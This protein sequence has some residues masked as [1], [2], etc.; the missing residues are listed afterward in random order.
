MDLDVDRST[1]MPR[2][3]IAPTNKSPTARRGLLL[4]TALM[5]SIW[6]WSVDAYAHG[7]GQRYDLP[8]PLS[9]FV[10]GAAAVVAVSFVVMA[11]FLGRGQAIAAYPRFNLLRW[12]LSRTIA[13]PIIL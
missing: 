9:L 6:A 8:V 11:V 7:F 12:S 10:S 2:P 1:L 5:A 4:R 13:H 3:L